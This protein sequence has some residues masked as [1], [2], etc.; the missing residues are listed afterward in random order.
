MY[1]EQVDK[2][3]VPRHIAF[4]MDGNG[5]WA[6]AQG[7]ERTYGHQAGVKTTEEIVKAAGR[8]GVDYVTLYTFSTENW[9]RPAEEVQALMQLLMEN[10]GDK[11]FVEYDARFRAIGD[12][13]RLSPEIQEGLKHLEESTKHHKRTCVVVALS[14]SSKW[15]LTKAMQDIAAEVKEGTLNP[16]DINEQTIADHLDTHGMPDP[17]L[18]IRTGGEER[19]SNFLLWQCAYSEFY[20]T[21]TYWP[22]LNEE[23]LC[24]AICEYQQRQRRFGKTGEQ[25]EESKQN[26]KQTS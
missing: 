12:R 3:R 4:I 15:E 10:L 19:I 20:F 14:Y 5:R 16:A 24:R 6:K 17:E 7:R 22:D 25:V 8:L 18:L 1:K 11:L 9:N 21:N 2:S 13:S 23:E 26:T